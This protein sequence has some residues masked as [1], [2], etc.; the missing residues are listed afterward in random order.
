MARLIYEAAAK[1]SLKRRQSL[2]ADPK[3]DDLVV[4]RE[5]FSERRMDARTSVVRMHLD[6]LRIGVKSQS[7]LAMAG[8]CRSMPEYSLI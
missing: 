5:K 6:D 3:P 7:N 4:S 2:G 8:S 1:A